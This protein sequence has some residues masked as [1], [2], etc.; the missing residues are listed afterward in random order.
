[1]PLLDDLSGDYV[2]GLALTDFSRAAL[3][4]LG[5]EWLMHGH[6]Q[7]RV[8]MPLVHAGRPREDM[9]QVAIAEW[10][11]AS[12]VYSRRTQRALRFGEGDVATILKNIQLDIGAPHHFLDF[13]STV[14]DSHHGEFF[15][16]HC[17]ALMDVEPMGVEYVQG[18]CHTIE[19]PTFDATAVATN[20]RAQV[21][22]LHRPPRVPADHHPHCHW[23]VTI[24][25][26]ADPVV[27]HPNMARV[28]A[29]RI[30][31]IEID[32]PVTSAE[33]GGWD[34][35]SGDFDPDFALEDLSH[36]ALVVALQ[37]V[38]VQSHLLL[39]GFVFAYGDMV[40]ATEAERLVSQML[41]GL[42]GLT[43]QRLTAAMGVPRDSGD[44][45]AIAKILQIHPTF[46]P[47]RYVDFRVELV[48]EQRVRFAFGPSTIFDEADG[49][50]WLNDLGGDT[51]RALESIVQGVDRRARC[52]TTT[53]RGDERYAYDVVVDPLAAPALEA[54][55]VALA[56][57]STGASFEFIPRRPVR[58]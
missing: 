2:P 45:S 20:P 7:D 15:L 57:I 22:P 9:E 30:A 40:G 24:D 6:L 17:G 13:R 41:A 11:A 35:Y 55:E 53:P 51:D 48:D 14:H 5:R 56:K 28:E 52:A 19:D 23:T 31:S 36:R 37:E 29:A 39:R 44:A 54:P 43:S 42:G 58:A 18:M 27:P 38:A 4:R 25:E 33:P 49:A 3:A 26:S 32:D 16:A 12:P 50:T 1:M 8:G 34:D 21:R 47:R 10:M 46:H